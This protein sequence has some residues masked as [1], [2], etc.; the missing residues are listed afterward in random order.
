MIAAALGGG[1]VAGPS[2][3]ALAQPGTEPADTSATAPALPGPNEFVSGLDL[4]CFDTP[5]PALNLQLQLTHLNPVLLQLGL[6]PHVV[7]IGALVQTCVPVQKNGVTP[8]AAALP[9]IQQT[10]LAC[11]KINAAAVPNPPTLTLKHLNPVLA[12]LPA[13]TFLLRQALQ[14]CV[15]VAKNGVIPTP[16]VLRLVQFI[17]LE[18]YD[19]PITAHP[20]F[21]VHLKQFNP[22]LG[23]IPVHPLTLVSQPRQLCVPVQKN[24]QA[25]PADVLGVVRWIDLEKFTAS[26]V[27]GVPP[28]N[29]VLSHLNPLFTTLSR[30][31]VTLA[32]AVALMVPVSKN[33]VVPPPP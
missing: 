22:Q 18:C 5:G 28:V 21:G 17:D 24:G 33:G 15:P 13:H 4:E 16:D 30:V 32:Q 29:V 26:P 3:T 1:L 8:S 14:L 27:V 23:N 11:Y 19:A 10:D 6:A 31:Q 25:I 9:F 20:T 7:T 2:S 12:N